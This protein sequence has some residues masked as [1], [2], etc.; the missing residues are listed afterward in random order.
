MVDVAADGL[1]TAEQKCLTHH[2]EVARQ[3]I[4][5]VDELALRI[6]LKA[7]VECLGR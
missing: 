6:G 2:V 4:H 3:W 5:H 1:Q 7:F